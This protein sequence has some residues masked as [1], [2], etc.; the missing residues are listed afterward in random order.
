M[1][2]LDFS[3]G[4]VFSGLVATCFF[5]GYVFGTSSFGSALEGLVISLFSGFILFFLT[6]TLKD[7]NQREKAKKIVHPMM[8]G[9]SQHVFAFTHNYMLFPIYRGYGA[10]IPEELSAAELRKL[11]ENKELSQ[12]RDERGHFLCHANHTPSPKDY[13]D[14]LILATTVD[15]LKYIDKIKPYYFIM[16]HEEVHLMTKIENSR[17]IKLSYPWLKEH[18]RFMLDKDSFVEYFMLIKKLNEISK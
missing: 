11:L 15:V 17:H 9:I 1:L 7:I 16:E 10:P 3:I 6:V 5:A 13:F 2:K 8:Q 18:G 4:T 12:P 14:Y